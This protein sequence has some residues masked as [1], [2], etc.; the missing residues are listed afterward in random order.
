[1]PNTETAGAGAKPERTP[2]DYAIEHAEYMAQDAERLLDTINHLNAQRDEDGDAFDS[3]A[4]ARAEEAVTEAFGS[5]RNGIYEF[6]K[7]RDRATAQPAEAQ[8]PGAAYAAP[9]FPDH[10][11]PMV[12]DWS[13]IEISV[14]A[15]YGRDMYEAGKRQSHGHPYPTIDDLCARIKAADDAA[16][17]SDY[18]L[19]S[20]DC[21]AVLRGEWTA[22]LAMDKPERAPHGQAPAQAAPAAVAGQSGYGPKVTVKRRC[23]DCK[24]CNSESYAVQGD[25]GHYVYCEHP[26][27]PERKYIGDTRWDTPGWCPAAAPT[28]KPAPQQEPILYDPKAL[29]EV[30]QKAQAGS[31]SPAGTLRGIAAVIASWESREPHTWLIAAHQPSTAA[32]GDARESEY[33]RGYRQGYEQRDAEVRGALV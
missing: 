17:D 28:T 9:Q 3:D 7:R 21:I 10:P 12:M 24:A 23:S 20:N 11:E 4:L 5:V 27:L 22:P 15:Q 18:M 33:Q 29:L 19:D 8:Q 6:R 30:F 26:S 2:Q 14:I 16:A 32:Q 31:G 1:M 13:A 25:S